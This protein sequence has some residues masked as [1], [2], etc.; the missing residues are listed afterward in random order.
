VAL[1]YVAR[2]SLAPVKALGLVHRD[3]V[4]LGLEGAR[5]D[6]TFHLVDADG[7]LLNGKRVGELV[8]VRAEHDAATDELRMSFPDGRVLATRVELGEPVETVFYGRPVA[9]RAVVGPW[10]AALSELAGLPVTLVRPEARGAAADRGHTV[11]LI[12]SASLQ[13]LAAQSGLDDTI[14][15][16]RFR[17]AIE[18]GGAEPYAEDGWVGR[19]VRIGSA[20][21]LVRGNVGRCAV[22]THDPDRGVPDLDTL[23]LL[24]EHRGEVATTEPLPLGVWGEIVQPGRARIGDTVTVLDEA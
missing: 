10:A 21:A 24:A 22:T 23:H 14:D 1:P 17:M 9:G 13:E 7:R 15:G 18:V 5:G 20:I 4:E 2:I 12:G 6:R 11:T 16:R 3:A 19:R 8:R